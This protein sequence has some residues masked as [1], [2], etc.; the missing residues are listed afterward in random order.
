MPHRKEVYQFWTGMSLVS[1]L[2]SL[3]S[4][5]SALSREDRGGRRWGI[6]RF[7]GEFRALKAG[8]PQ[9]PHPPYPRRDRG[10]SLR[11]KK[12]GNKGKNPRRN[13]ENLD[14][15][16]PLREKRRKNSGNK[17]RGASEGEKKE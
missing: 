7:L 9:P 15:G 2:M 3:P 8:F 17:D 4:S 10:A 1:S 12:P 16:E 11:E 6:V 14:R 13:P 5:P